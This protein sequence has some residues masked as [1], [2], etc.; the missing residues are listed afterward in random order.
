MNTQSPSS[1]KPQIG[2]LRQYFNSRKQDPNPPNPNRL[3]PY[4]QKTQ[5]F[6]PKPH[7][8]FYEPTNP[9]SQTG[10]LKPNNGQRLFQEK[11][12]PQSI[13]R[14]NLFFNNLVTQTPP[15]ESRKDT[16][17]YGYTQYKNVQQNAVFQVDSN[18]N[19]KTQNDR[20]Y[21]VNNFVN[22]QNVNIKNF[23]RDNEKT[24]NEQSRKSMGSF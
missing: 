23:Y 13:K 21:V 10:K 12:Q 18:W 17:Q 4:I 15:V 3:S 24:E 16:A 14:D 5:P 20:D 8:P 19:G 7:N 1:L 11:H 9:T 2:S 6:P 22:I